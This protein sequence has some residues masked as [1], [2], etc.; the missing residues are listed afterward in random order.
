MA[1]NLFAAFA[2]TLHSNLRCKL[3]WARVKSI[4]CWTFLIDLAV[5]DLVYKQFGD[6]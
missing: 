4:L 1:Q 2:C 3:G 6:Y 5:G